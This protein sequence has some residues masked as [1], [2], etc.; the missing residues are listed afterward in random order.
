MSV[1]TKDRLSPSEGAESVASRLD[2]VLA[3]TT[4]GL[5]LLLGPVVAALPRAMPVWLILATLIVG[6]R[7]I[8]RHGPRGLLPSRGIGTGI[9]LA[10]IA[11]A[12][13]GATWSVSERAAA[14]VAEVGYVALGALVV[15]RFM[16]TVDVGEISRIA[17]L[18]LIGMAT[19][20]AI[21]IFDLAFEHPVHHWLDKIPA[22]ESLIK[23]NVPKRTAGALA[24]LIWPFLAL[25]FREKRFRVPAVVL[26]LVLLASTEVVSSRSALVGSLVG[27]G[28]LAASLYRPTPTRRGL[29]VALTAIFLG[30]V[31]ITHILI[32]DTNLMSDER[33]FSSAR[34]RIEIWGRAA[35]RVP[36]APLLGH[37]IDAARTMPPRAGETSRFD[38]LTD[39][40][41]PLHP[42]NAFLE[43]W[44]ELGA[45]GVALAIGLIF[46][47]SAA[48]GRLP[49]RLI[50]F[51][52]AQLAAASVLGG[53]AYGVWQ[54]WWMSSFLA[55]ALMTVAAA[56]VFAED[57]TS[58]SS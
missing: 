25:A 54:A 57:E 6:A 48:I 13:V 27:A 21:W 56:R 45:L 44:L 24:L 2:R 31:P 8:R 39:H 10:F 23:S 51:A 46:S 37:G 32:N 22:D 26:C 52:T 5:F 7:L 19:G 49:P 9:A 33:L 3:T 1:V 34:H 15:G 47:L 55:G 11:L 43:I 40:L 42:H 38:T 18:F 53:V 35:T 28:V 17:R 20:F 29:V 41:F 30:V 4:A 14:T 50:P 12:V 36:D 16:T 58:S